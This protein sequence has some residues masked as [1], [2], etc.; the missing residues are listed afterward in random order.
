MELPPTSDDLLVAGLVILV[1]L[2]AFI[3]VLYLNRENAGK[4]KKNAKSEGEEAGGTVLVEEGGRTVR[5]STRQH[6]P[7]LPTEEAA[8]SPAATRTPRA[9]RTAE[10]GA[11]TPLT[12]LRTPRTAERPTSPARGRRTTAKSPAP[13]S[14]RATKSPGPA[15]TPIS[16]LATTPRRGPG[17]PKKEA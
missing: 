13:G 17:R 5:R 7:V 15:G 10:A 4:N 3:A 16:P 6:K 14:R 9:T 12:V 2:V 1:A 8:K 11:S